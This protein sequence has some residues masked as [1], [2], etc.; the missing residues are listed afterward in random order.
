MANQNVK[1]NKL[2]RAFQ[3]LAGNIPQREICDQLHMGR[4]VLAKYKKAADE[5]HLSYVD[6]G[7]M[8]NEELENFLKSTKP[9]SMP[10][11]DRKTMDELVADYAAGLSQNRYLTIQKLHEDYKKENPDGYGYTQFKKS[12][13]DYQYAHNL[14]YHNTYIPGEEMQI[15]FAGDTLWLTDRRTGE[16]SSVV[17]LVCILPFSG[18]GYAKAMPNASMEHFF[19]GISDAFTF[20]G[21]TLR[22]AKSDNMKQWVK[23][24]D[25]YEPVFNDAALE[26]AAYYDTSLKTCRVKTPRDKGP[27]EGMVQKVYNAVY[28]ELHDEIFYNID[29][30][31]SRIYELMDEF[32]NKVSRVTG[33]SR[34][35]VF[36]STEKAALGELPEVP[37]RFRFRKEVKLT[38]SYHVQ[39]GKHKY[40]VPYQYVGQKVS[41]AWDLDTVEVYAGSSRI[42]IH[43]RSMLP[44]YSTEDKHMPERHQAYKH[45]QGC[46]AAYFLEEASVIGPNTYTAM[47]M[48]LNRNRHVEQTYGSCQGVLSLRRTYGRE[49]LEKACG[50]ISKCT[51][52]TYTMIRN[53]L[54][55]NLDMAENAAPATNTPSNDYV[56]GAEAFNQILKAE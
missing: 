14:S 12:I 43:S 32:N 34:M 1:M 3:M 37:F 45:G 48:I 36:E 52:V 40:S 20:Y 56:R 26:W 50:R 6:A 47:E 39:I 11:A 46:N 18:L 29:S 55:K 41:V 53:I 4:G 15:D 30:M 54:Q 31:N 9:V 44:G 8:S 21:G 33:R 7:Q 42:A 38:G 51:S 16:R 5:H 13:R 17:V 25:R 24:H 10:S 35:D 2:K 19:G 22:T 28:S 27:V 23:K 49:R